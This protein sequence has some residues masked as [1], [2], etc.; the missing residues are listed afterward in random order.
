MNVH[1]GLPYKQEEFKPNTDYKHLSSGF[2]GKNDEGNGL[3]FDE[4]SHTAES[5]TERTLVPEMKLFM[6]TKLSFASLKHLCTV[7]TH[8]P[9]LNVPTSLINRHFFNVVQMF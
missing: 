2:E 6:N 3:M 8:V 4:A 1:S 5:E 9:P 7:R